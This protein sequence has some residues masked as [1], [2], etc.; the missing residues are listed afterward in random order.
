M[1]SLAG[2][3]QPLG[4]GPE[5]AACRRAAHGSL[6]A[7]ARADSV[8]LRPNAPYLPT[9]A[10]GQPTRCVVLHAAEMEVAEARLGGP[11][12]EQGAWA[13]VGG[14]PV[15]APG[16]ACLS[17]VLSTR[18]REPGAH[19][20]PQAAC[21]RAVRPL[22]PGRHAALAQRAAA[23]GAALPAGAAG[24]RRAAVAQ[25]QLPA[26]GGHGGVLSVRRCLRSSAPP[27]GARNAHLPACLP[28]CLASSLP[29]FLST[30]PRYHRRRVRH[31]PQ[32]DLP[33]AGRAGARAGGH[34]VRGQ[35]RPPRLPL[36]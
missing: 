8:W 34:P 19:H 16:E 5:R 28:V 15:A 31:R 35:L 32:V 12:G 27:C 6:P 9:F 18:M 1:V 21:T 10:C 25:L 22:P 24:G 2:P 17:S 11:K 13:G 3:A 20:L 26:A 30:A 29:A 36:L 23:A 7:A 14:S 33:G 4:A